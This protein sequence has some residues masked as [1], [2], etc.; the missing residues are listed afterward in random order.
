MTSVLGRKPSLTTSQM[1][2][3]WRREPLPL[4]CFGL[5]FRLSS[6]A[7]SAHS[8][9]SKI[10][11]SSSSGSP[12]SLLRFRSWPKP[13]A[14]PPTRGRPEQPER[15]L[16]GSDQPAAL[17]QLLRQLSRSKRLPRFQMPPI[18]HLNFESAQILSWRLS[19]HITPPT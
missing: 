17:L 2:S 13:S 16:R 19:F 18:K 7:F 10:V 1:R 6:L 3:D 15:G 12:S 4:L 9:V 11:A 14:Q 8:A 5:Q